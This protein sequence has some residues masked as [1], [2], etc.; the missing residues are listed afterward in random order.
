MLRPLRSEPRARVLGHT[1][2]KRLS[3]HPFRH[4][5]LSGRLSVRRAAVERNPGKL[6]E[7]YGFAVTLAFLS[8][9]GL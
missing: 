9:G 5:Q 7:L 8:C 1:Y 3:G 6:A 4:F 2:N